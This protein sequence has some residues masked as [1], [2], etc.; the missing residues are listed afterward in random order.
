[1]PNSFI[2]REIPGALNNRIP[3]LPPLIEGRGVF[4]FFAPAAIIADQLHFTGDGL[5]PW[6]YQGI[7][8][9]FDIYRDVQELL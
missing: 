5:S 1:M 9:F 7:F 4:V 8:D 2:Y 3:Y 6:T